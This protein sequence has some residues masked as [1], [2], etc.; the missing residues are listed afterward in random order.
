M[1]KRAQRKSIPIEDKIKTI[2]QKQFS[3]R[4][5]LKLPKKWW[6]AIALVSIFFMVLFF[7]TYFNVTSGEPFNTYGT[8]LDQY[9]LS[10]PDPYYNMRLV[11]QTMYGEN[12]GYY[13]FYA[14]N[15]P[16]LNYPLSRS[17]VRRPLLNMMSIMFS[18]FLTPFMSE[19]D[20][21]GYSMQ[22]IPALF[23]ALLV[24]PVYFIG[25]LMFNKKVG[26]LAALLIGLIPIHV[27]SGHGSAY[28]LF[29]HDSFNLLL[30]FLTYLFVMKA[31]K[32][33]DSIKSML[34]ALLGGIPLA[35]L[36]MVW[37][38]A[39]YLYMILAVYVIVQMLIDI[40]TSRIEFK[41]PRSVSITLFTGYIVSLP[42]LMVRGG[43][44]PGLMLYLCLGVAAFGAVYYLFR[45][46]K[47]PW[48]LSL[49]AIFIIGAVG[50]VFL[51][52]IPALSE[53]F[54]FLSGLNRISEILYGAGIYGS[55]VSMTI[56][57]AGTYGISRSVMSFG[58]T[59]LWTAFLGFTLIGYS[60]LKKIQRRDYL[61]ILILFIINIWF[62][63]IAGRF[64][65]DLVP[66]IALLS[67]WSI[68]WV[69]DRIDYAQMLR[70]IQSAGGGIH[71]IRRGVK[72]LHVFGI[73]FVAFLV[74]L[75]NAYLTLDAAVPATK[76]GEVFGD[77]PSGA[78]GS[79]FGKEMYWID[80]YEWFA[81]QDTDIA[82]PVDRP[83][84]ISWWDY[85]F[86]E[87]ATGD[88]PTVAD[89]FQ[90][91][92]PPA[93][94]FHTARSESEAIT[95]WI[96]RL[97]EGNVVLNN[98]V[99]T[100]NVVET[101]Q[102][103]LNENDSA[104]LISWIEK[105]TLSPSYGAPI[106][107]E[108]DRELAR[109]YLVGEQYAMNAVYHD[110]SDMITNT[111]TDE[112]ITMF[113][114]DIQEATG[115]SI[116]Y[117]GVEGYDKDIF[118]I[119]GFLSDKSLLL[120]SGLGDYNPE[121]EFVQILYTT[122]GGT[123]LTYDAFKNRTDLENRNDPVINTKTI[124]KDAYFESMFYQTYIGDKQQG[125]S[126][127][128]TIP[129]YHVP[130]LNM[131]HFYAQYISPYGYRDSQKAVVI[132]KYYEGAQINGTIT[133]KN[134]TKDY[135]V[136]VQQNITH[137]EIEF[138]IDHDQYTA[139][140]GSYQVIVPAGTVTLQVR[141]YP[142]LGINGLPMV[143]ITLNSDNETSIYRTVTEDEAMRK[144]DWKRIINITID[145][146]TIE[147]H[148]YENLD[149]NDTYNMTTDV[150]IDE[151]VVT[152]LG[153]ETIN[154]DTFQPESY[155]YSAEFLTDS[156]GFYNTTDLQPGYYQIVVITKEGFQIENTLKL[157]NVGINYHNSSKPMEGGVEG[158]IFFDDNSNKVYDSGEEM[159]GVDVELIYTGTGNN[160]LI[161]TLTTNST[162]QYSFENLLPGFYDIITS[163]LPEY[164]SSQ[165]I[166]ITENITSTENVSVD[167]AFIEISGTIKN[168]DTL[169]VIG[170]T[171]IIFSVDTSIENNTAASTQVVANSNGEYTA[172]LKPGYYDVSVNFT[173]NES[174]VDVRYTFKDKLQILP[175]EGTRAFEILATRQQI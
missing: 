146:G 124:Y 175:G 139:I 149:D 111:L 168:K 36:S 144:G 137:Y 95:V 158:T 67:A 51:F 26:L 13:P 24:F 71:G 171:S 85:G 166:T 97:L 8:G 104:D 66:V 55:K 62:I 56:A 169:E 83:G 157:V 174:G 22:F 80:A 103:H 143:N 65:N 123:D 94:N 109:Q 41:V 14:D 15:D 129:Q 107:A 152:I 57:E 110:I 30:I 122:Q 42:V 86:Y 135:I 7:N 170:N 18:Q 61:F 53:S 156:N 52:F 106:G 113:Y 37:V 163:K 159:S 92:I 17:G 140:N 120:V 160:I 48:T 43:F 112:Q 27:G 102:K 16:L 64:I 9:Y 20:S 153:I 145:S 5:I 4:S 172:S 78:F 46:Q 75:P 151:A 130:C 40:F 77:L 150:P 99:L 44:E 38:E 173:V 12:P 21:I 54:P 19:I 11:E 29:D 128:Y 10:G 134:E 165:S 32:E 133:Y 2:E 76:K 87:V 155:D 142:E 115:K 50:L 47:L 91:G 131:K 28:S 63:G 116:R 147:G 60:Y 79:S 90:D 105:P 100:N 39:Q 93:A 81:Q 31:V 162:G 126:G 98:G 88:H 108:F 25:K 1:R 35:G 96:T 164:E 118:N 68:W 82:D 161:S 117:Y 49:P 141:R 33:R 23:G 154:V 45:I 136:V 121:D 74:I 84:F 58:P 72:F 69:L 59:L 132:A 138:P 101:I 34:Y 3:D 119:F 70:T 167:Y 125:E 73:L 127:G 114:H 6:I 89:N 148:I